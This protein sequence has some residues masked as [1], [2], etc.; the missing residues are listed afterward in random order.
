[1]QVGFI[2]FSTNLPEKPNRTGQLELRTTSVRTSAV[3]L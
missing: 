1:M 3:V 2:E